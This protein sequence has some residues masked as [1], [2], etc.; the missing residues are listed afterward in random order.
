MSTSTT[1]QKRLMLGEVVSDKMDKTI[2]VLTS[3][4]YQHERFDKILRKTKKYKVH[5]EHSVAK[6]GDQV[7]FYE[8]RPLS[9]SKYMMLARV[10]KTR[11]E[12][13]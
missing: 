1:A 13:Q 5:D 3:I 12:G 4:T 7:E 9:K 11:G 6:T 10:V 2:V 8:T